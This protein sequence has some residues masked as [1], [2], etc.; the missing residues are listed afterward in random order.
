MLCLQTSLNTITK[1]RK[2]SFRIK[3]LVQ[4]MPFDEQMKYKVSIDGNGTV[5]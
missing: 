1:S 3:P 5:G 4:M 2:M